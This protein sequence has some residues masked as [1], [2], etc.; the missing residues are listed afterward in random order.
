M[1]PRRSTEA[2]LRCFSAA[3]PGSL[4]APGTPYARSLAIVSFPDK[5]ECISGFGASANRAGGWRS[6]TWL[7]DRGDRAG[8]DRN[9]EPRHP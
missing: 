7:G 6:P 5:R 8:L 3:T 1:L 2:G 9:I 4:K